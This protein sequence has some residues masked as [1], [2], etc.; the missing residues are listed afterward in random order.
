MGEGCAI[1]IALAGVYLL[2][3]KTAS[4]RL[5]LGA[6]GGVVL[7]NLV[8]RG[9]FGPSVPPLHITL[10]AG[11]TIYVVVFMVTDPVSAPKKRPAQLAYGILIGFLIVFLQWRGVF[12][13]AATFAVLLG[14][15][16]GPLLDLVAEAWAGRKKPRA[17]GEGAA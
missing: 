15:L 4:W 9:L 1:L 16:L 8:M 17:A 14:N 6:L 7:S 12:V 2:V 3:T 13:V 11:T 5:M 10:L